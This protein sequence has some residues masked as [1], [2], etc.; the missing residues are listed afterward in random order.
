MCILFWTVDNHSKYQFIF[1]GNR[2][3]FLSRPTSSAHIW[4]PEEIRQTTGEVYKVIGGTDLEFKDI[5]N[6]SLQDG[7]W[8]GITTDGRFSALTNYRELKS[9]D[10]QTKSR[11]F[12]VRDYLKGNMKVDDYLHQRMLDASDYSGYSLL[13]MHFKPRESKKDN[14]DND[15]ELIY[16]T[17]RNNDEPFTSIKKGVIY[18]LSNSVLTNPWKKV[19]E[20]KHLFEN[21]VKNEQLNEQQ[22]VDELFHFL[23]TT[24]P[25]QD[26]S[27]ILQSL[28]ESKER[29]FFPLMN[30]EEQKIA[31]GT[32]TSTI[33]L[34]DNDD[35][36]TFIEKDWYQYLNGQY[37]ENHLSK[38]RCFK[39]HLNDVNSIQ[40][41]L[42]P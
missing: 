9:K 34:M 16:I 33:I 21:I 4:T 14:N 30:S 40:S 24:K 29:I 27:N 37:I 12:L 13:C 19:D 17:N 31:Y 3:E 6:N 39:F 11:G 20:G 23:R 1:A 36:I 22:L 42:M 5:H 35:H 18:G 7:T 8:L 28:E 15:D 2:D 41:S 10:D 32:R 26:P 38:S 25:F